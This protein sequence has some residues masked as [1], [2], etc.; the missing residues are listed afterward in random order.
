MKLHMLRRG[1]VDDGWRSTTLS[2][3]LQPID[4]TSRLRRAVGM[5]IV[6]A[7]I[8]ML[9][10]CPPKQGTPVIDPP[11]DV[12]D[13]ATLREKY[14][15][16]IANL[17]QLWA[18]AVVAMEWK[19]GE[20]DR[21]EQGEGH[22]I[23]VLPGS[24]YLTVGKFDPLVHLGSDGKRYWLFDLQGDRTVH[25]GS[26]ANVGK[27]CTT[28][29]GLP[30]DPQDLPR[31]MGLLP[32]P[33]AEDA[34][35]NTEPTTDGVAI[36]LPTEPGRNRVRMV[37]NPDNGEPSL[38][39]VTS[40]AGEPLVT[41]SL[42]NYESVE[43]DGKPPGAWPRVATRVIFTLPDDRGEMRVTLSRLTDA[44]R[45]K[46]IKP[47][48]FDLDYLTRDVYKPAKVVNLDADCDEE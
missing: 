20:K 2:D 1:I 29:L 43:T 11:V 23:T 47:V 5:L 14:N 38:M 17:D 39:Q 15:A 40:P 27:P 36:R 35:V 25:V 3:M 44:R 22:F 13:Y 24:F 12:V 18:A 9:T 26:F 37:V 34:K 10:G 4:L 33:A 41:V 28:S 31:L 19:E 8:A 42:S 45:Q 30:V 21:F 16:R 6:L 7:A 46:R 48:L 32:L